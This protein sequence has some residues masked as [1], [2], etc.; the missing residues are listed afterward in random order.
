MEKTQ[1]FAISRTVVLFFGL[2]AG[3]AFMNAGAVTHVVKFGGSFGFAY[4]PNTL[5]CAVGDTVK[6]EG[7]FGTHPLSS[8]SVPAGAAA[9]HQA[10]GSSFSYAVLAAG[11]YQYKCDFHAGSGMIGRFTADAATGIDERPVGPA[12]G[13]F[14]LDQNYPN[15]FNPSTTLRYHVPETQRVTLK[16]YD[17]LGNEVL[18]LVDGLQ[19]AGS[20]EARFD[21]SDRPSG[22]YYARLEADHFTAVRRLTLIK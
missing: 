16:I 5:T 10:S 22:V 20:R 13:P 6:W 3:A 14:A 19:P 7:D 18:T 17:V 8:T 21:G 12:P 9:L 11:T 15:P 1:G 4:S 2:L